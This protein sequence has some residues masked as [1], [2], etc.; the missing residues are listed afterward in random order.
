V[1]GRGHRLGHEMNMNTKNILTDWYITFTGET[2]ISKITLL[3]NVMLSL[4]ENS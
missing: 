4:V 2:M 3:A 1:S